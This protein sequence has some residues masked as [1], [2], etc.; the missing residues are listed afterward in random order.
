MAMPMYAHRCRAGRV[1]EHNEV[2]HNVL[3][4]QGWKEMRSP[5]SSRLISVSFALRTSPT[6]RQKTP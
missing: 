1:V 6:Y 4:W 5:L 2:P 3:L